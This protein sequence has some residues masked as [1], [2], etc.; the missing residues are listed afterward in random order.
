[1]AMAKFPVE[2]YAS[3]EM[4]RAAYLKNGEVVSQLPL[5]SAFTA[6]APCENGMWVDADKAHGEIKLPVATTVV[7]GIVYTTEKEYNDGIGGLK[8][9]KQIA[10]QYPRVGIMHKG[11]TFTTNCAQY[12]TSEFD[13]MDALE[14]ALAAIATTP[15]YVAPV[16]NS[17]RPKITAT[18]PSS[19]FYGTVIKE[20][21]MPN[22]EPAIKYNI[23]VD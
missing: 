4:N 15:L 9:F 12:D 11:D 3:L 17:G 21:T 2:K 19:G 13:D 5:A 7:Y 20:F 23:V 14:E 6:A 10:G 1:M 22:G 16:A 18:K 8:N